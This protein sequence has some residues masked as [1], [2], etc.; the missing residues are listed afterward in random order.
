MEVLK[1]LKPERVFHYFE[2]ICGIPHGSGNTGP[3]SDYLV[4]FAKEQ[5]LQFRKDE[6]NNVLILKDGSRG[7]EN[8]PTV[9]LQGHMD[10]VCEKDSNVDH[11]FEKDGLRLVTDG[12]FVRAEGTTLGADDGIAVAMGLAV[13]EDDTLP[14]PPLEVL[15]TVDEEIGLLGAAGF[16]CSILKG[17]RMLNLDSEAEDFLWVSCAGGTRA[18]CRIPVHYVEAEGVLCRIL[19]SGLEG[20]HSGTEINK[21]RANANKLLGRVLCTLAEKAEFGLVSLSGG[22]KDNAITREAEAGILLGQEDCGVLRET[23][24]KLQ[25]ELRREYT[26]TDENITLHSEIKE[27][28]KARILHP[29]SQAKVLFYLR[30][31]PYGV[32]KM[33]GTIEGL[34]ETS[35]NTGIL[36]MDEECMTCCESVRSSVGSAMDD[37]VAVIRLL[38]EFLGGEMTVGSSYPAWE[39][40][41]ESPLRDKVI[42][43]YCEAFGKK[44][45]VVAVHAGLECGLFYEK[46]EGLDCVSFGPDIHD[47]HTFAEHLDVASVERVYQLLLKVLEALKD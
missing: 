31:V 32:Q 20:G 9:I 3:I 26:G 43:A 36:R 11:D 6:M 34:V 17:K 23:L 41:K 37:V 28:G 2:E 29:T 8:S 27:T 44:P 5:G 19:I 42:S 15:F 46:I 24:D 16:D 21:G 47:I 7:Y 38:T 18:S 14:H 30:N 22:S 25:E 4:D 40:R 35:V 33:S 39:Y 1:D 10:M 45:E 13:L 12:R